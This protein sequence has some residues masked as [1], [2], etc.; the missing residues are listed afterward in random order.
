LGG[1]LG[2][3]GGLAEGGNEELDEFGNRREKWTHIGV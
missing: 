3:D 1:G 2:A